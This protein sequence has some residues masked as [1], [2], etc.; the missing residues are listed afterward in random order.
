VLGWKPGVGFA[1]TKTSEARTLKNSRSLYFIR[2]TITLPGAPSIPN[3]TAGENILSSPIRIVRESA[4]T[5]G[6]V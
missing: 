4:S 3:H 1:G 6:Q 5:P 2:L